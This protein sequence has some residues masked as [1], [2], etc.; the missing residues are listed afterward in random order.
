MLEAKPQFPEIN[1]LIHEPARLAILT[2][3]SSC[4]GADFTFLQRV[5]G[6]SKGNLSVQLTK[7]EEAGLIESRR[8]IVHRKT[9]TS[10]QLTARGRFEMK[11]YWEA[12]DHI[13][14]A[15][16]KPA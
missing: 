4:S 15:S 13:R 1:R 10:V 8:E 3:L 5:T 2:V 6:L 9:R 16:F 12:L 14:S 11:R 7:I